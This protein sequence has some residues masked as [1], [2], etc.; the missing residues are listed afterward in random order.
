M[1]TEVIPK[2]QSNPINPALMTINGYNSHSN[3]N[4]DDLN[5]GKSGTRGVLMYYKENL[6]VNEICI[7]DGFSDHAWFEVIG[8]RTALLCGC[9]YRS[10]SDENKEKQMESVTKVNTL[11]RKAVDYNNNLV[12]VGDFNLKGIDWDND[13]APSDKEH[14][15]SFLSNLQD[16][17][18]HQH[19]TEPTRYRDNQESNILDLVISSNDDMIHELSYDSPL[20]N[21]DHIC[22]RFNATFE[23]KKLPERIPRKNIFK[24]NYDAMKVLLNTVNWEELL[25][26]N[27]E[28]GYNRF[29]SKLKQ[30]IDLHCPSQISRSKKKNLYVNN[31]ALR[32]RN[33]KL[34]AWKSYKSNPCLTTKAT[35]NRLKNK[36]RT[37]TRQ[38][39][40]DYEYSLARSVKTKP[41]L[42]WN[43]VR[44]RLSSRQPIPTLKT[45]DGRATTDQS[46]AQVLNDFFVSVFTIEDVSSIPERSSVTEANLDSIHVTAE[47][48][49]KKLRNLNPNKSPG[50][51]GIHSYLLK[52]LADEISLPLSML[53]NKSLSEGAHSSWKKAVITAVF[54]K[55]DRSSPNN[56]RPVS[57]TSV[58]SKVMESIVR[59][60]I[61]KH[62]MD[63]NLFCDNQHGFVPGRDCMTQLLLCIE[64]WT[65][66]LEE[67]KT[68][69]IIY[70]DFAKAFDSVAHRR[71]IVK[72]KNLG[73][74]GNVLKWI[75]SLLTGRSQCVKVNDATSNWSNVLSGIPQGSVIGPILFVLFI[76]DMPDLIRNSCKLFADDCKLYS[77]GLSNGAS[78]QADLNSLSDWSAKWQLPFNV[79][80]CKVMHIGK[81]NERF[82]YNMNGYTL[83]ETNEEKDL[84]VYIDNALKFHVHT[85][86]AIKKANRILGTIK[87][88]CSTR[89]ST[90]ISLLY[91]SMVRPHLEYGNLI[92]GPFYK[93]DIKL[94]EGVQR[95][96]TKMVRGLYN[97]AYEERLQFLKIPSLVYR[98]R[99][100]DMIQVY[101]MAKELN[102]IRIEDFFDASTTATRGHNNKFKKKKATIHQRINCFSQRVINDWNSLPANLIDSPSLNTF[103]KRLDDHWSH[104]HYEAKDAL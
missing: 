99:R 24:G 65:Q 20:G 42:F 67:R 95:R 90:T 26:G 19:V 75:D 94:V 16:C 49:N 37:L 96:A 44:S 27:F 54:K 64:E 52:Q 22:L 58:L 83:E 21:S 2:S 6:Q 62:M 40:A 9:I 86:A 61:L 32:L 56:Y 91:K 80:K 100:G 29:I 92:W 81:K 18:L 104:L 5:L 97:T 72:L 17:F 15:R 50:H 78:I 11:I 4:A 28:N 25:S 30:C 89:D 1:I 103:K 76:N 60:H 82:E 14:L 12:I 10:P 84:G 59:D 68:I 71:L 31:S 36:L 34:R 85:S 13:H 77:N 93:G 88:S 7:G 53:Y 3:F 66:L 102:R 87:K 43:Y 73:I 98:R 69:D 23:P 51:D 46:K 41:K 45:D 35:F 48:V 57:L 101:K 8:K 70:T 47:M 38:L 55:G 74:N 63:N 39:R 33:A 79:D